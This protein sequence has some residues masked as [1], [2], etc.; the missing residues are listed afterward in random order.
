MIR[1]RAERSPL[2][3]RFTTTAGALLAALVF[4]AAPEASAELH[5]P[6]PYAPGSAGEHV[7]AARIASDE[8]CLGKGPVGAVNTDRDEGD[9]TAEWSTGHGADRWGDTRA[10]SSARSAV[11]L[12]EDRLR[13]SSSVEDVTYRGSC[14]EDESRAEEES[15]APSGEPGAERPLELSVEVDAVQV[16]RVATA[17]TWDSIEGADATIDVDGLQIFGQDVRFN[18]DGRWKETFPT[19]NGEIT[20][21]AEKRTR[22]LTGSAENAPTTASAK[23]ALSFD[24]SNDDGTSSRYRLD[25][26]ATSVH[27][28]HE[29][30]AADD[31]RDPPSGDTPS[32]SSGERPRGGGADRTPGSQ[33]GSSDDDRPS[34][35]QSE[36]PT[37][38]GA[39]SGTA[40]PSGPDT[41]TGTGSSPQAPDSSADGGGSGGAL[42][43]TGGAV[44]GLVGAALLSVFGGSAAVYLARPRRSA[45]DGDD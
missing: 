24:I 31:D 30:R 23:L 3:R 16:D 17:A 33:R 44:A 21:T 28:E 9:A 4:T 7:A 36:S 27:S 1:S 35:S 15:A 40:S 43:I 37:R 6:A 12:T 8:W 39:P 38:P 25:L 19:G 13:A 29:V 5:S 32:S 10:P 18:D 11:R 26:A 34:A 22:V 2:K 20:A 45:L 42:P 14:A 41:G